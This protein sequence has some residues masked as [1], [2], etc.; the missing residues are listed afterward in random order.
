MQKEW[1]GR[2]KRAKGMWET[3]RQMDKNDIGSPQLIL[4][5]VS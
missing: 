5:P 3:T 4:T 2:G 1:L